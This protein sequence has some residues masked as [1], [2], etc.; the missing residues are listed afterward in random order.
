MTKLSGNK[1][2]LMLRSHM[3]ELE[4]RV[5]A[6]SGELTF[7]GTRDNSSLMPGLHLP[8]AP[9]DKLVY[10][11]SCDFGS[12]VGGYGLRCLCLHYLRA[13]CHFLYWPSGASRGK[14]VQ[15]QLRDCTAIVQFQ[16]SSR[17]VSAASA[18]KSYGARANS[19]QRLRGEGAMTDQPPCYFKT[20][21]LP[22]SSPRIRAFAA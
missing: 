21:F 11:F 12:I 2:C 16:C 20:F 8:R 22:S 4:V 6:N 3:G 18:R 17:A 13:S 5:C 9:Y 19:V 15:R 14:L 7:R 10:D 1:Y